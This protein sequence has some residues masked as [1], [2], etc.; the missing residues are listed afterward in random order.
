MSLRLYNTLTRTIED[1]QPLD[2]E[3]IRMYRCGPKVYKD[4]HVGH[5]KTYI[6]FDVVRRY[7]MQ[8]Y[9]PEHVL[10]VMNITDVGHLADDSDE[11]EDKME[12]QAR[13]E[14]RSP[15]EIG[16]AYEAS[17]FT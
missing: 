1:F 8:I 14:N 6:S 12:A 9:G 5:A 17:W 16:A 11:G 4:M 13:M 3:L 7:L 15:F 2:T 10:Y